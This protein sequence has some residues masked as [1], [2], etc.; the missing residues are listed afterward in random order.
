M[1][2]GIRA[3]VA[4]PAEP[5]CPIARLTET[6]DVLV[7]TAAT[8]VASGDVPPVTEFTTEADDVPADAPV[9]P[10]LSYGDRSLYRRS[11]DDAEDCPCECLGEFG[12]PVDR[13]T[14]HDGELVLVFHATDFAE[15]QDVVTSLRERFP[16]VDIR[17]LVRSPVGET[18]TDAVL[19]D[20]S[21]LTARQLEV[22]RMAYEMGYFERPRETNAT[23]LAEAL[24]IDPSTLAEHLAAAQ[25]K[26]LGDALEKP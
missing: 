13:Y 6:A 22:V 7:E 16:G 11:H 18:P 4:F 19:V 23:E 1:S 20:R 21:R 2:E 24:D 5:V 10:V 17:R 26:L 3:T 25:R 14:A 9:E 15:L 8:S 12:C